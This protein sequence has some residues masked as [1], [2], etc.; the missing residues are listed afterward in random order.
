M[1][2]IWLSS[3][4]AKPTESSPIGPVAARVR[5]T[6]VVPHTRPRG[7]RPVKQLVSDHWRGLDSREGDAQDGRIGCF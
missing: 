5:R 3:A 7:P 4:C 6:A 1:S 2:T